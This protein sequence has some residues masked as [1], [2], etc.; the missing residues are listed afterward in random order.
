[1]KKSKGSFVSGCQKG[2]RHNEVGEDVL[3]VSVRVRIGLRG[4]IR[5]SAFSKDGAEK[6]SG[7]YQ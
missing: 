6:I 1:M 7:P 4:R 3:G 5:Q 2:S